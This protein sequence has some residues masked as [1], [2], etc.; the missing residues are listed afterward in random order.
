V[1]AEV[2][3]WVDNHGQ[4]I[5]LKM[6]EDFNISTWLGEPCPDYDKVGTW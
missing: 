4:G 3:E 6:A 5:A 1:R 2:Q